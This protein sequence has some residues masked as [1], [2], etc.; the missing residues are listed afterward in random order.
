[1]SYGQNDMLK[2]LIFCKIVILT[3]KQKSKLE[4][5]SFICEDICEKS[6]DKR[7]VNKKKERNFKDGKE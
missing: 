3:K 7:K 4:N 5:S 1:M 2:G 6:V